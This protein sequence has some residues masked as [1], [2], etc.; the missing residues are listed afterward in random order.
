[1]TLAVAPRL[2]LK[3]LLASIAVLAVL[4]G[5]MVAAHHGF[6]DTGFL[7][8]RALFDLN[9]EQNIPTLFSTLQLALASALLA[10]MFLLAGRNN[11]SGRYYWGGLALIFAFLAG[12]EFCEWHET[13]I[14]PMREHFQVSGALSFGWVIPYSALVLLFAAGYARF[15]W[16]LPKQTRWLFALSA[17]IF[18]GGGIGM[19]MVGSY[20][21]TLYGWESVQ[22][23]VQ[24]M[25][26]ESLEM[27]G[28]ALFVYALLCH[29][30]DRV[31]ALA[32]RLESA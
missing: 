2:V 10:L 32:I 7:K 6:G 17:V 14:A 26:E 12:D 18:V 28:V 24:T 15:W 13:L 30:R 11:W 31:G 4:H 21:F 22:F 16:E 19:E 8:L 29:L 5:V 23:D 25:L 27:S 9:R 1:M 3:T 20:L